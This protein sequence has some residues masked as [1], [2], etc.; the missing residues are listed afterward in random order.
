MFHK[1]GFALRLALVTVD[2]ILTALA[3]HLG[4]IL[5]LT[6]P[7]GVYLDEPL[8]FVSW[9]YLL[10][11]LVW[12]SVF[13]ALRVYSPGRSLHYITDV[14]SLWPAVTLA[15]L[16]FTGIAYLFFRELSRLLLFYFYVLDLLFLTLWRW[17][18]PRLMRRL[19]GFS[20]PRRVLIV[21]A[22]RPRARGLD[23][24][25]DAQ[26]HRRGDGRLPGGR[27]GALRHRHRDHRAGLLDGGGG[28]GQAAGEHLPRGQ[29]RHGQRDA[30][31][32]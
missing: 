2:L 22:R 20:R 15:M 12:L 16:V 7:V 4:R 31:D 29:H 24:A 14:Q 17:V 13:I 30:A 3:L 28:D 32:V 21:G 26:G 9:F 25:D 19:Q 5:R 27:R 18:L 23:H 10:V 8:Q 1:A 6:L 11:P